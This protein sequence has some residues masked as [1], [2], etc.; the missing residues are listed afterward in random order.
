MGKI[1]PQGHGVFLNKIHETGLKPRWTAHVE[2][3]ITHSRHEVNGGT[4]KCVMSWRLSLNAP[5]I[6]QYPRQIQAWRQ[7]PGA[8]N[9]GALQ[10]TILSP[11]RLWHRLSWA[12][13]RAPK[14]K[15]FAF[16]C[17]LGEVSRTPEHGSSARFLRLGTIDILISIILCWGE[18]GC[19]IHCRVLA[20]SPVST[21]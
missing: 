12:R 17:P 4:E 15:E 19:P 11:S 6:G 3:Y 8:N 21:H 10:K 1:D 14:R 2:M 9:P 5:F 16:V 13:N 20:A 18:G 7:Q